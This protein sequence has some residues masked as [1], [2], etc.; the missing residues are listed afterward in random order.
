MTITL[1]KTISLG[2]YGS[3][4]N[5]DGTTGEIQDYRNAHP[6]ITELQNSW[7]KVWARWDR[8][9]PTDIPWTQIASAASNPDGYRYVLALDAQV[10]LARQHGRGVIIQMYQF[11]VWTNGNSGITP[12][13]PQ[14]RDHFEEDRM[15]EAAYNTGNPAVGK[16]SS[17][18]GTTAGRSCS[19]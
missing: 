16:K 12:N 6:Y 15:T 8:I 2:P 18:T 5:P 4:V 3:P 11:P 14:D 9:Q 17:A 13:T 7:V 1:R 10:E 19:S